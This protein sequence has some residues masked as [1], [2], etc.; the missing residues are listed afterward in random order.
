MLCGC[1]SSPDQLPVDSKIIR[2]STSER[3]YIWYDSRG[4]G[5]VA[6]LFIHCWG[7]D[8]DLWQ[9]QVTALADEFQTI[10]VDLPGHD[11]SHPF[12]QDWAITTLAEAVITVIDHLD[13]QQVALVGHELGALISLEI[14]KQRPAQVIGIVAANSLYN[15]DS[16]YP[17]RDI[18]ELFTMIENNPDVLLNVG[19]IRA[20]SPPFNAQFLACNNIN[21][22]QTYV[23]ALN[24][25]PELMQADIAQM[26][27]DAQVPIRALN[28]SLSARNKAWTLPTNVTGN[29]QYADF[30]VDYLVCTARG[31]CYIH[32]ARQFNQSLR[33]A[34]KHFTR[35]RSRQDV[36]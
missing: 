10:T 27:T 3:G 12:R 21:S 9:F 35:K 29:Q 32:N 24:I 14:A 19:T 2:T 25:L 5:E 18:T 28:C 6:I 34:V 36:L 1:D 7:C 22:C 16:I 23:W 20:N 31:F 4:S 13:L 15:T 26:L 8:S 33:V 17:E 30:D 11:N